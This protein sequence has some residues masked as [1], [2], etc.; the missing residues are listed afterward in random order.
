MKAVVEATRENFEELIGEGKVL[1][2]FWGPRCAPCL[3][4]G[5]YVDTLPKRYPSLRVVKVEAP[6]ARR[7]CMDS[8]VMGLPTF[9]LYEDGQEVGR[10]SGAEISEEM[11]AQWL[12]KRLDT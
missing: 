12:D 9:I 8:K 4:L 7:V 11:L 6:K 5:P 10:L 1:V 2:D 3:A